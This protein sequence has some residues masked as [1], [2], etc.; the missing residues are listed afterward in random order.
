MK[1]KKILL[2]A[3]LTIFIL[4][5]FAFAKNDASSDVS[6]N[7]FKVKK[8]ET[9]E[10]TALVQPRYTVV[11]DPSAH[12][13]YNFE[14][15]AELSITKTDGYTYGCSGTLLLTGKH[16]LTA[17]HCVSD[18]KGNENLNSGTARFYKDGNIYSVN[19]DSVT[20]HP[21]WDG[22]ILRGNDVAIIEL[23]EEMST[24]IERYDIDRTFDEVGNVY[25]KVGYGISGLGLLG[26]DRE[27]YPFGYKR[28]GLNK[29]DSYADTLLSALRMKAGRDYVPN[30]VLMYDF[31]DGISAHDA[32][33]FFFWNQ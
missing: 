10:Y 1:I 32:F 2:L 27:L 4:S 9:D 15:V 18:D 20:V 24:E 8:I 12:I 17:A 22:D 19:F 16:V 33:G 29:Y 28:T 6:K 26:V 21:D 31:D 5:I 14:G 7:Q 3:I 11:D 13:T 30:S 23:D 25:S